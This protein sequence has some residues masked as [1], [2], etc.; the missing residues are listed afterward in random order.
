MSP[1]VTPFANA[2]AIDI[3]PDHTH[4][5]VA[6]QV[7][8]EDEVPLWSLPLPS[9]APRRL[10]DVVA[11]HAGSTWSPDQQHL[12]FAHGSDLYLANADGTDPHKLITVSGSPWLPRFSP[13]GLRIRFSILKSE[14][15]LWEIR[16]DGSGL[17]ALFPGENGLQRYM[18][19]PLV[20][21]TA[22]TSFSSVPTIPRIIF[23][24][25][26]RPAD[27]YGGVRRDPSS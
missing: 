14:P 4:L 20:S 10:A 11:N 25:Y 19:R 24:L 1:I 18:L 21:S 2:S 26:A 9:G 13:D 3:S 22:A 27:C 23:G 6:N 15:S 8:T 17:H 16:A 5:L 7:A 12:A